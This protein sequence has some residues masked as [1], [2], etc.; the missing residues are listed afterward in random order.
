L[1]QFPFLSFSTF[2]AYERPATWLSATW[3]LYWLASDTCGFTFE[4]SYYFRKSCPSCISASVPRHKANWPTKSPVS[5]SICMQRP[6][7]R[8]IYIYTPFQRKPR[9]INSRTYCLP[10]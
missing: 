4:T 9:R 8:R 10:L 1:L 5:L 2:L 7:V 6:W 3:S